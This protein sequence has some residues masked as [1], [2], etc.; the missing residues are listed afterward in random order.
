MDS[1]PNGFPRLS[2]YMNSDEDVALFRRFGQSHTRLLNHLQVE[3]TV[4]EKEILELDK[5]D[6]ADEST[7][8]RLRNTIQNGRD[9]AQRKLLKQMQT[10]LNEYGEG[11]RKVRN[12]SKTP[13][14]NGVDEML[15]NYSNILALGSPPKRNYMSLFNW[16]WNR[17]PLHNGYYDFVFHIED[18]VSVARRSEQSNALEKSRYVEDCIQSYLT[19]VP[20]SAF[21]VWDSLN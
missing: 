10:K 7:R 3:I 17:K 14:I 1:Y 18:F 8:Q 16:V 12:F 5:A 15:V 20:K 2:A 6:D 13:L 21:K 9:I 4:L 19:H 11:V